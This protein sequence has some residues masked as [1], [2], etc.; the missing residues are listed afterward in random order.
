[1]LDVEEFQ[2]Y[3]ALKNIVEKINKLYLKDKIEKVPKLINDLENLLKN[4]DLGVPITYI[5]S[6]IA[7]HNN[8]LIKESLIQKI[9]PFIHSD[10]IKLKINSIL[11]L[12]FFILSNSNFIEKYFPDF[13][14]FLTNKVE[15]IRDNAH[16]FLQEFVKINP[17]LMKSYSNVILNALSL[18]NKEE[19]IVSLLNFFDYIEIKKFNFENLYK[20][21]KISKALLLTYF[22]N[23]KSEGFSKIIKLL[24]SL[25]PSL[26]D[27]NLQE[28][29][30]DEI[31]KLLDDQ[32][33][34]KKIDFSKK[35][36][37]QLK[38]IISKIKKSPFVDKEI[39]FY[40]TNERDKLINFYEIEKEKL[41]EVINSKS[42][43]T[44]H[45]LKEIFS[46]IIGTD[47]ELKSLMKTL[48]K[49]G[50]IKG[51]FSKLGLFY[52]YNFLESE[53]VNDFQKKGSVNLD[54]KF[55]F[56]PPKL[57]HNI[58]IETKQDFLLSKT[59]KIYYS[60]KKI[61]NDIS[62]EAAKYNQIDLK[63]YRERLK[64]EHFIRLI[65]NLP[66]GYLTH[67]R[68]G[69]IWL[70]NVG[71]IKTVSE[72]ENSKIVGFFDLNKI[73][74]KLK[75]QKILLMDVL[76]YYIDFRSGQ[77]NK[78]KEI[79]YYS[80]FLMDKIDKINLISNEAEKEKKIENLAKELNIDKNHI[81][82]KIDENYLLIGEEI[83]KRDQIKISEYLEKTGMDYDTF[84]EFLN[85]LEI[86]FFRKGDLMIL[87]PKKIE[88]EKNNIKLNLIENSKS[89]NYI[90][91]GNFDVTSNLIKNLINDLKEDGK[92][93][94]I[95]YNEGDEL[96]FYTEKGIRNLMLENSFLFSFEDLFYEKELSEEELSLLKDIFDDLTEKEK[97]KGRFDEDT[98]T[99]ESDDVK[100]A[101]KYNTFLNEFENKVNK[102]IQIFNNEFLKI[103]KIL[104]KKDE[105]IFPQEIK[106]IQDSIDK[107][108]EKY[109]YW[110]EGLE[111]F[112]RR[113]NNKMLKK[114][115]FTVK[116]F[117][118]LT[119][120]KKD[121]IKSFEEEPEVYDSLEAFKSWVRLFNEIESK[122]PNIIF[123]KKRLIKNPEDNESEKKI[124]ELLIHLNLI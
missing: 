92:L 54:K 80:K 66:E 9:E 45:K 35:E 108:N 120:E 123:Y 105:T 69:T 18:E 65:K 86:I 1:M 124:N 100:F 2:E 58:I 111:S 68:K 4:Q 31:I 88:D 95:F 62:A 50:F 121:D 71:K 72:I 89:S 97:L 43:I 118:S 55:D 11:I 84:L 34:M 93:R 44:I 38:N 106:I 73:S 77:W 76:E 20:F 74:K 23:K 39:Y 101:K 81:L 33:L 70:T 113:I 19:N 61:H 119:F 83:K 13:A 12:G 109:I 27:I 51:Y 52:P 56:L 6:I 82:T 57:V 14:K 122:Y 104:V 60:L 90:S 8:E 102:Y 48:I 115:G 22:K 63:S 16:Y 17:N 47:N 78:T 10:N 37:F 41:Y 46:E 107:I 75:I 114:Q 40:V 96:V 28:K 98:L 7:E 110:R 29:M 36:S 103:K 64:D 59:G 25:F 26:K 85:D 3:P 5:L 79:F 87:N 49:L 116:R 99:F 21:R 53:I 24:K 15:D 32:F 42:K 67:F 91:L 112:V 30:V 117:K 94:G